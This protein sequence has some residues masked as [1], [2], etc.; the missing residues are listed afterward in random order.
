MSD[1]FCLVKKKA[2]TTPKPDIIEETEQKG[3]V[4]ILDP[5]KPEEVSIEEEEKSEEKKV[6]QLRKNTFFFS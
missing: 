1:I 6:L 2:S 5:N 3:P 4:Q